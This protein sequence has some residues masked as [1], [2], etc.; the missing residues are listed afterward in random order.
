MFEWDHLHQSFD[1]PGYRLVSNLV[2]S[3][4]SVQRCDKERKK[5]RLLHV[6]CHRAHSAQ[7]MR[8][9]NAKRRGS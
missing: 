4:A 6:V 9:R 3:G 1:D 8:V 5:C 7:Q 2:Q